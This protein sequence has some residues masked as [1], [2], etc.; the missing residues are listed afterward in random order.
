MAFQ[1]IAR[2]QHTC[3]ECK[4]FDKAKEKCTHK[5]MNGKDVS[6]TDMTPC[7]IGYFQ[8]LDDFEHN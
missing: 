3:G 2:K 6:A 5:E 4:H 8:P 1:K 7:E